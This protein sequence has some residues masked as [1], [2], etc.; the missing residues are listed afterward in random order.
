MKDVLIG[1]EGEKEENKRKVRNTPSG[2]KENII[3]AGGYRTNSVEM[4]NWRQRTWLPLKSMP[5]N[6]R[7]A[8]TFIYD[9]HMT[10]AGGVCDGRNSV[11]DIIKMNI[12][13]NPDLSTHWSDCPV[14][15]PDKLEDHSSVLYNDQLIVSGGKNRKYRS[16]LIYTV[17]LFPPYTVKIL[18]IS[19]R[20]IDAFSIAVA[21]ATVLACW[22]VP[23]CV[24]DTEKD[25]F[26]R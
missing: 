12:D 15:L 25:D 4:F 26:A 11:D 24:L 22:F 13:P 23:A 6:R 17:E 9:N 21:D 2:D 19:S 8:T 7:R 5:K 10:I 18:S 3:V 20:S 1:R 14:K 16:D